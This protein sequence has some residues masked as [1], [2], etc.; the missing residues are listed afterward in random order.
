MPIF[1]SS[2]RVL[3]LLSILVLSVCATAASAAPGVK[4][5]I[6]DPAVSSVKLSPSGHYLAYV[7]SNGELDELDIVDLSDN[8]VSILAKTR[9]ATPEL[10]AKGARQRVT[11]VRWKSDDQLIV[12]ISIPKAH[13]QTHE[14]LGWSFVHL[15]TS[16]DGSKAV[17]L[18]ENIMGGR[19]WASRSGVIDVL[20]DDPAHVLV[21]FREG[22]NLNVYRID[23]G[24]GAKTLVEQGGPRIVAF[25]TDL[26]G[27]IVTRTILVGNVSFYLIVEG[28]PVGDNEWTKVMEVHPTDLK[29]LSEFE[30]LG[31]A[32]NTGSFY[33]AGPDK[34]GGDTRVV[35]T[36]DLATGMGPVVWSHPQY[37]VEGIMT[38]E[39]SGAFVAGCYWIDVYVCDFKDKKLGAEF[40]ALGKAFK[41]ESSFSVISQ[42]DDNSRWIVEASG[43]SQPL[44]YYLYDLKASRLDALGVAYPNLK[45]E[46]LGVTRRFDYK[47]RDGVA[48]SGYLTLPATSQPGGAPPPL[49]VMPHGGPELRDHLEF[50][51]WTQ[52]LASRGYAVL[53]PNFRG[54]SGFGKKFAEAGYHQWGGRMQDDVT[55]AV[56]A[57]VAAGKVDAKRVCIV[58]ASYGGY[59]A[60]YA[61]AT[62]SSL[63]RCAVD[64]SGE[65][66]LLDDMAWQRRNFGTD[67]FRYKY[68]LKNKGDPQADNAMLAAKSPARLAKD[69]AIPLLIIHGDQD[70]IVPVE[71]SRAMKKA[72]EKAGRP[73]TY[74][75]LKDEGHGDWSD[76]DHIK[77]L[78]EIEGFLAKNIGSAAKP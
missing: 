20:R 7:R 5:F 42:A 71:Q 11:G 54:S 33:V 49:V 12:T 53:Q 68:W 18:N 65:S 9:A 64:V 47:S 63:Y 67:S 51:I 57:A 59:V 52:F 50:D 4:D 24:T 60:L 38:D 30:I 69:V 37:D 58:G 22:G 13:P 56:Q 72:M 34:D 25:G 78:A 77:I 29:A 21:A 46:A 16:R 19:Q 75:E 55:D 27:N 1:A 44:A 45:P 32:K 40:D 31:P 73:V 48:L 62:Q 26:K 3:G 61:A 8:K 23:T 2:G 15:V 35:R 10:K 6:T 39:E 70:D 74:I 17:S 28:R 41:G 66:D 36:F 43:P 14:I 76:E